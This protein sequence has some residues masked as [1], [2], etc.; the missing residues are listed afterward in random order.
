MQYRLWQLVSAILRRPPRR[1][2]YGVAVAAGWAGYYLWPRGRRSMHRNYRRVL[3]SATPDEIRRVSRQSLVNYCKYLADFVRF[4]SRSTAEIVAAV[5]S[6]DA[7]E[8]LDAALAAGNGAVVVCMHFGNWDLGA[9]ATAGRGYP[10]TVVAETF[11]DPR[12]DRMV[13][14]ARERLGMQVV[15]IEK[16][17]PSLL[18]V[19]KRN[20]VLALLVDRPAPGEGVQV[21]F[22]GEDVE[23]PVGP[24]R[25]A[26][27]TGAK[28]V[29]V[30][31]ERLS[32]WGQE[33]RATA[34]FSIDLPSTGDTERDIQL[35]MQAIVD[36]HARF[37]RQRPDQWYMFREMWPRR[38]QS[39]GS[40]A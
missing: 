28:V 40:A 11:S 14:G 22:F 12:L 20:E 35:L 27:R 1:A 6:G 9:G 8:R 39:T 16:T 7:F 26:L 5:E 21:S 29:P 19:L 24:A 23:V 10:V 30:A 36:A 13:V 25:L 18:R 3:P 31:F 34:D 4:P 32:A 37:I 17:S 15:K 33:V 38:R 2:S